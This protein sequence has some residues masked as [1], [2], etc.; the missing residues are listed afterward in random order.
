MTLFGWKIAW[1]V[2]VKWGAVLLLVL[3]VAVAAREAVDR[4]L[5][6]IVE[7]ETWKGRAEAEKGN[8]EAW[9]LS[10]DF[11]QAEHAKQGAVLSVRD[12]QLAAERRS[13]EK[14][15]ADFEAARRVDPEL[16]AWASGPLPRFVVEQ[17][18]GL[19]TEPGTAPGRPAPD[20][21][22]AAPW[23]PGPGLA[24]GNER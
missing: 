5:D 24:R 17:L 23:N 2:L 7:A 21:R 22:D 13:S 12:R 6:S 4:Y 18:R 11:W 3:G 15:R 16:E 20:P 19:A 9:K 1:T 8:A 14:L 10:A